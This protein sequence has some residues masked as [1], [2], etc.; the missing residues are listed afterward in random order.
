MFCFQKKV[1][2]IYFFLEKIILVSSVVRCLNYISSL[3]RPPQD[4]LCQLAI[5]DFGFSR[6]LCFLT[7]GIVK[8]SKRRQRKLTALEACHQTIGVISVV[9]IVERFAEQVLRFIAQQLEH[10]AKCHYH[11]ALILM[12]CKFV[13]H[14]YFGLST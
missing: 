5:H 6:C 3:S 1:E 12:H 2:K 13:I 9:I 7:L 14:S 4:C 11:S 8:E 10:S